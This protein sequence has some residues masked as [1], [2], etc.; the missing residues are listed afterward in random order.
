MF[1][2]NWK[3]KDYEIR[4]RNSLAAT[5]EKSFPYVEL[6]KWDTSGNK[7]YCYTLAYF[8]Y[9]KQEPDVELRFIGERPFEN[10]AEIDIQPV[11]KQL[12]LAGA[13]MKETMK[14]VKDEEYGY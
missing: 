1:E 4:T 14:Q 2:F 8:H 9:D 11:W 13:M 7:N 10:I 12:W 5:S 3:F 6:V